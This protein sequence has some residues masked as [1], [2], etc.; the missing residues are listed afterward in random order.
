MVCARGLE[1]AVTVQFGIVAGGFM[2]Q[3]DPGVAELSVS[4]YAQLGPLAEYLHLAVPGVPVTRIVGRAG[5]GEQGAL[6]VL[7]IAADS[8]VL[9]AVIK[10]LPEF[11]R[12]RKPGVTITVTVKG[13]QKQLTVTSDAS[14]DVRSVIDKFFDE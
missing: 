13:K 3:A 10:V 5:R 11:L 1:S 9:I 6:D 8:S 14:S 2:G 12:S 4:D 7:M